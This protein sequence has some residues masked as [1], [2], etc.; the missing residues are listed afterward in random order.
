MLVVLVTAEMW[1]IPRVR[2]EFLSE[3]IRDGGG[4]CPGL[5]Q[6]RGI[7]VQHAVKIESFF[8]PPVLRKNKMCK[9]ISPLARSLSLGRTLGFPKKPLLHQQTKE[10]G[11]RVRLRVHSDK[12]FR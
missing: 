7:K 8:F 9:H 3:E 10:G 1:S 4:L 12:A 2:E 5:S 6:E 11:Q